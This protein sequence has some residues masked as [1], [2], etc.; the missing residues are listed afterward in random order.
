MAA[1]NDKYQ[2]PR[3]FENQVRVRTCGI[4]IHEESI[5]LIKHL[6]LGTEGELWIPPGGGV[7]PGES[8]FEN[9]TRE[10]KEETSIDV[11]P[12][13]VLFTHEFIST[14]LHA[15]EFFIEVSWLR[16]RPVL[17]VD[18]EYDLDNQIMTDIRFFS[19]SDLEKTQ[20]TILHNAFSYFTDPNELISN[21][22]HITK[23]L[24]SSNT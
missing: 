8:L 14:N 12:V 7:E 4:L 10:F 24:R 17:G 20:K 5:L 21:K 22:K 18:P 16:G 9:I 19:P 13:R 23:N 2:V 6:G 11:E 1:P 3:P 15:L